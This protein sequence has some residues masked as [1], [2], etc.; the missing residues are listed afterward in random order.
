[1][2]NVLISVIVPVY[3]AE[4]FL[5]DCIDSIITQTY[6]NAQ[7]ILVNDGSTDESGVICDDY[8]EQYNNVEVYHTKNFGVSHARNTGMKYIK[9][10]YVCFVDSDDFIEATYLEDLMIK[11]DED[12][13]YGGYKQYREDGIINEIVYQEKEMSCMEL[14]HNFE[15][16]WMK[17]PFVS[18]CGTCFRAS[19]IK[20]YNLVFD[21]TVVMGEDLRFNIDYLMHCSKIRI[22]SSSSYIYRTNNESA[23]H[24]FYSTRLEDVK[25]E[26]QKIEEF[27]EKRSGRLEWLNWHKVLAHYYF[28][29][30]NSNQKEII[31][32]IKQAYN[33]KYFKDCLLYIR[34]RGSLD[35]RI[36]T[37]FMNY[38][39]H[40]IYDLIIN[41]IGKIYSFKKYLLR[42]C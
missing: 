41:F 1:M 22:T 2:E 20:K 33:D 35:E 30:R 24:K 36:E 15:E 28:H 18:V 14:K 7:I 29:Y 17:N 10:E 5:K 13:V 16:M 34:R 19:I 38:Y 25:A 31:F 3:N 39:T 9:G 40:G 32:L 23:V 26:C 4:K 27:Y 21:E 11:S 12:F 6:N 37:Y 42:N 8:S